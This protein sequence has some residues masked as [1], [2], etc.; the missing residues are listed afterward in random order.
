MAYRCF[1]WHAL[2][3]LAALTLSQSAWA[4]KAPANNR[5]EPTFADVVYGPAERNVLDFYVAPSRKPAP[6]LIRIHEGAFV[7]GDKREGL[8]P[9]TV[10]VLKYSGI[11]FAS[12]NYRFCNGK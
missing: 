6:L 11:H 2:A 12:I 7:D 5:L 3:L 1:C 4:Q 10:Q 8:S 9:V